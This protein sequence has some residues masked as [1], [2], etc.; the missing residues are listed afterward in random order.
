VIVVNSDYYATLGVS[1]KAEDVVIRAAYRALMRHY[2]PDSNPDPE[3]QVRARAITEAYAVLRDREKRA[4]Y[5]GGRI[6]PAGDVWWSF[7]ERPRPRARP[8]MRRAGLAVA[9]LA[10][11]TVG[12]VWA[13][14]LSD[15]SAPRAHADSAVTEPQKPARA[16]SRP[17]SELEPESERL[18]ALGIATAPAA[19]PQSLMEQVQV[20]QPPA[21]LGSIRPAAASIP[22]LPPGIPKPQPVATAHVQA[23]PVKEASADG[24]RLAAAASSSG[25]PAA[26]NE[27]LATLQRMSA[28]FYNQSMVHADAAKKEMLLSAHSRLST[29]QGACRSDS[30]VADTYL[31]QIREISAIMENRAAPAE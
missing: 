5:D 31:R 21:P 18:A 9:T 3:A 26:S 30:C 11:A 17:V 27:R 4:E 6:D 8:P 7:E 2:H 25:P 19:S 16:S 23:A 14:P 24:P 13:W 20:E 15:R 10:A 12:V 1:P 28:S 22:Q 29:R